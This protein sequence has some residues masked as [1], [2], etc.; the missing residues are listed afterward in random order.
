MLD[1]ESDFTLWVFSS[2]RLEGESAGAAASSVRSEGWSTGGKVAE[3][4]S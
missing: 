1:L 4:E 2:L 3:E